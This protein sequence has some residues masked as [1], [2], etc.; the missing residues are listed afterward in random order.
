MGKSRY[1][2]TP[3]LPAHAMYRQYLGRCCEVQDQEVI[4]I[5]ET[6]QRFIITCNQRVQLPGIEYYIEPGQRGLVPKRSIT[7]IKGVEHAKEAKEYPGPLGS[8]HSG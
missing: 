1:G 6:A 4:V 8:N 5:A 7:F 2:A 3:R